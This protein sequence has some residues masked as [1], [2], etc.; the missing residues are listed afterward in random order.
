MIYCACR[1]IELIKI[2]NPYL[3]FTV[4]QQ[5]SPTSYVMIGGSCTRPSGDTLIMIL[6]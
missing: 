2:N 6:S 5:Y 1:C 4:Q 3:L